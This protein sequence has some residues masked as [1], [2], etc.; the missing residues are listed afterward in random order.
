MVIV[1]LL[2]VVMTGLAAET[3]IQIK[4]SPTALTHGGYRLFSPRWSPDGKYIAMTGETYRGIW[5]M[6]VRQYSINPVNNDERAGYGF[7]W[8]S[9]SR[10]IACRITK[11]GQHQRLSAI[12][13]YE[14]ETGLSRLVTD[15][16]Q[17]L[18]LPTW[19]DQDFRLCFMIDEQLEIV[20]SERKV[21]PAS[22]KDG[23]LNKNEK[24]LFESTGRLIITNLEQSEKTI[25]VDPIL[26][27]LNA[28]LSPDKQKIAF[29]MTNGH[30]YV[31][32]RDGNGLVDLNNGSNPRWAPTSDF[33]VYF[34]CE[35]DGQRVISSELYLSDVNGTQK[36][37]ITNTTDRIEMHPDWS[38][39]GKSIIFDEY[40]S[41]I[42]YQL[43]VE[44]VI[45]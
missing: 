14:I 39:D 20:N 21:R 5:L 8:S 42:I 4:G 31:M 6:D 9:D 27:F 15:Y 24:V 41:G 1:L 36:I 3:E 19:A 12:K 40:E 7:S 11:V 2:L 25:V 35:D 16:R 45:K 18:G 22:V 32:N 34:I 28:E 26:R 17:R 38:P 13:I 23:F 29:E 30:I 33:L 44:R 37:Q 43:K 10:E